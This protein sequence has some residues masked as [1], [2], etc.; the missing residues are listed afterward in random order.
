MN[1][2][3]FLSI[4][5]LLILMGSGIH[6]STAQST[7]TMEIPTVEV[8]AKRPLYPIGRQHSRLD[9]S[10]INKE[11][12]TS[13]LNQLLMEHSPV[14]INQ[15]SPGGLAS[16]SFR[17]TGARHSGVYWNGME[18]TYPSVGQT[19]LSLFPVHISDEILIK[20]G[21]STLE[22][23]AGGFGGNIHL[24]NTST[25][26]AP[27]FHTDLTQR[28][29]S[30]GKYQTL[31]TTKYGNKN[32]QGATK[33]FYHSAQNNY[34]YYDIT[35][36]DTPK[37][38]QS[39]ADYQKYGF[40]QNSYYHIN[41]H[42]QIAG[43]LWVQKS[44]RALPP[45]M[46]TEGTHPRQTDTWINSLL[47]WH[48]HKNT[49]TITAHT[50]WSNTA[51]SYID[52]VAQINSR[53][54]SH[55][56]SN[57]V[58][59]Q[60]NFPHQLHLESQLS[61]RREIVQ[62]TGYSTL[63]RRDITALYSQLNIL[64]LQKLDFS[65]LFRQ[66]IIDGTLSPFL[67]GLRITY[68]PFSSA[69]FYLKSNITRNF[70]L[71]SLN[72]LYWDPGG[73]PDLQPEK[74]WNAEAILQY[75]KYLL[76][77]RLYFTTQL[78]GFF[79]PIKDWISWV[80]TSSGIWEARNVKEVWARGLESSINIK[81]HWPSFYLQ[82][83]LQYTYTKTTTHTST[84]QSDYAIGQQLI[85]TPLH[86]GNGYLRLQRRKGGFLSY[87]QTY[88][89]RRYIKPDHSWYLPY[90]A[91][92]HITL[93][94]ETTLGSLQFRLQGTLKNIFNDRYQVIA[95][96]PMPGRHFHLTLHLSYAH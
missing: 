14:F 93:G 18:I 52:T 29:G 7:D 78:T 76:N 59:W 45:S 35:Q 5:Q 46:L 43:H 16:P 96:R 67:P 70:E 54:N 10:L 89:G 12:R 19:D 85:Y 37:V 68:R 26:A 49:T 25:N 38:R 22:D 30:F 87:T 20:K 62:S 2:S 9:S 80:P 27:Q 64:T 50:G 86:K 72:D 83:Q 44:D 91:L 28:I 48:Y 34:P 4:L 13:T 36:P 17:G 33:L 69:M 31:A 51:L 61:Y 66:E 1:F 40:L 56:F 75:N 81:T 47:N 60:E 11:K 57:Q 74:G 79:T 63:K 42:H 95:W 23:G 65:A 73:N 77:N 32:L 39:H 53:T 3:K 88:T 8:K 90:Y 41:S 92:S 84:Q 71:P 94:Y 82:T 58:T 21:G 6:C 55:T 15:Y 24:N